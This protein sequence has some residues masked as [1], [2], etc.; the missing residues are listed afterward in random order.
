MKLFCFKNNSKKR[1]LK[2]QET[3]DLCKWTELAVNHIQPNTFSVIV[4]RF[5]EIN[6][7]DTE[8]YGYRFADNSLTENLRNTIKGMQIYV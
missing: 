3:G 2:Y 6:N 1:Q 8:I 7:I 4:N 5:I